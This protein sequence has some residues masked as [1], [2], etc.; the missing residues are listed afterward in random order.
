MQAG[1]YRLKH[2]GITE[3]HPSAIS[4]AMSRLPDEAI[5]LAA[6]S[7][8][9]R[10]LQITPWNL[11]SNFVA[12]TL[13][14]E[15][16][17]RLEV[18]GVGDP[19]GRGLGFSY[20]R[21]APK[22]SMSTAVV[23]KK[24]AAGRGG[25]TVTGTDSDLRRLS[26]EAARE[27]LLKF[28][29]SDELIA[30]QTRWH[31]IAMIR[32]LSSE[33][34]ASG[35][36][37][38]ANTISKYA[39]GH[40]MSFLQLQQQ[41]REKCQEIWE[42][43]VQSLS[44]IDGDE[45]E[46]D[47]EGNNS[48]LDSFAGDLENLLDAEECE[49][50]LGGKHESNHDKADGVK[51]LKMRRR[52]SLAQAEEEIE[53]EAAEAAE[54]CRLLMDDD[55]AERKKK[56]KTRVVGDE[57][58]LAPSS[59]TGYGF[60]NADGVK[61]SIGAQPDGSYSSKQNPIGDA[62]V[63]ENLL[64][65]NKTGKL[66]GI[67][68]NDATPIGLTNKKLKISGDGVKMF[69]EKKSARESFVCGACGQLGHMR[70]NKNCPKYGEDHESHVET[71]DLEKAS[72]K[73]TTL[74]SS[75]QSQQKT[76][77]KK[78]IQKSAT[79][80]AVVEVS[81]VE[82]LG[83]ST[84]VLPLK[85]K[86]GSTE[87]LADKQTPG[88]TESSE[89]LTISDT[90]TGRSTVKVNKIIISNKMKPE[91]VPV[92]SHK[93]PI[94]IRPPAD[95]DKGH[96]EPL[97]P[98]IVIRPPANA[99]RDLVESQKPSV[100]KQPS[101]EGH[102][103]QQ[104][105]KIIIKRP[106]EKDVIDLDRVSQDGSTRDEHRKTKRIVELTNSEK[107]RKQDNM[108]YAKETAKKKA[109]KDR[110]L[111]EEQEKRRNEERAR[112]LQEEEMR[113]IEEKEKL[114]E[115]RRYEA[116]IRQEREEEERQKARNKKMKKR[117]VIREDYLE[118]SQTRRLDKRMPERD[119]GTKR[120][121]VVELGR[122]GGD[123]A[124]STKRRRGG[125]VGLANILEHIV[126]TLKDRIEVSYLFLK[127]VSKKE[128]PDYLNFVERPMDLSTIRENVRKMEYKS[129]EQFRH[130]VAQITI[131]AHLYNDGRN[132]GIPPLADQLLEL[133][134]YMLMEHDDSLTEAE[135]GIESVDN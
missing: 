99:D 66:K 24:S 129:R 1:L 71:P 36:K 97:K 74:N 109:T 31:R 83:P 73:S 52:P 124:P 29:V 30:R 119:R 18:S 39:R 134:D 8:I 121:P 123:S 56:K 20:V 117:P 126:E 133:C 42:R 35:V 128:A 46:S 61:Q 122:Y 21:A 2:L 34:A 5:T 32:K 111:W 69:K 135:A 81:E 96:G 48:D 86:C 4:S 15:T 67:K 120:R 112:R 87:K 100:G 26:M 116:A 114:V 95:I 78:L 12:C 102:K 38:D 17:E 91:T 57:A 118:D 90:E 9:E 85:F 16:I 58:R 53:D 10:E 110:R 55:E 33:Q 50:G 72:G 11:S 106:K 28:G 115:L 89:R 49:E 82:N 79:K 80:I 43:Q 113:M 3:T 76:T 65:R 47:S 127:P 93:P 25:S 7:H 75:S 84:K 108:H 104:H 103:E 125:E 19:S 64:K 14:K 44:A 63:M 88:E 54:L 98:T 6:A 92:E 22:A 70:T 23:K 107:N 41:N 37:V 101:M 131:N 13:G 77:A 27:V 62:K 51:G 94:V 132:P 40:R 59:R 45:N 105:K 68:Q 130:D 60:E